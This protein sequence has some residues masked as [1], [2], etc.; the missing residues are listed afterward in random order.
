M[1]KEIVKRMDE[2][3]EDIVIINQ[4]LGSIHQ[5]MVMMRDRLKIQELR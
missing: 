2:M 3:R 1:L 5:A 4:A